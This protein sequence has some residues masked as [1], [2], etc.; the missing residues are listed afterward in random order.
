M[1]T[2]NSYLFCT[3][4]LSFL[5]ITGCGSSISGSASAQDSTVDDL[6]ATLEEAVLTLTGEVSDT[7]AR[8]DNL[9]IPSGT[10]DEQRTQYLDLKQELSELDRRIDDLDDTIER[11]YRDSLIS[12]ELYMKLARELE[13]LEELIDATEEKLEFTFG[14]DD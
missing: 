2:K 12:R 8:V 11:N 10:V 6:D 5:L 9:G 7:L 3:L 13:A 1:F 4:L 14:I